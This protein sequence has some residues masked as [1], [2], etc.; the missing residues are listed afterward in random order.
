MKTAFI[1]IAL[2]VIIIA[3]ISKRNNENW[4][5]EAQRKNETRFEYLNRNVIEASE[6]R[7]IKEQRK[8]NKKNQNQ[9][10]NKSRKWYPTGWVFNEETQLWEPPDYME[11]DAKKWEW[12]EDKLIWIDK[13][14]EAR[15]ERYSAFRKS[16]GKPPTY[17]EW[18]AA[19]LAAEKEKHPEQ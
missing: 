5:D 4:L 6:A 12:D 16:Q 18:K 15:K 1:I 9:N 17:E 2:A 11:E 14:R 10:I 3:L 7:K 13:E 8:K 19:K